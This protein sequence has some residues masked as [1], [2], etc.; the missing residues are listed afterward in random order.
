MTVTVSTV[1]V[2]VHITGMDIGIIVTIS[3]LLLVQPELLLNSGEEV[4]VVL[5]LAAVSKVILAVQVLMLLRL[6]VLSATLL[7]DFH[8]RVEPL[9]ECVGKSS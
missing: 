9:V 2:T 3:V 5:L 8:S 1:S 6:S 7:L 4:V